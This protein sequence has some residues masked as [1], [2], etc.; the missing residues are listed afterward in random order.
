MELDICMLKPGEVM[1]ADTGLMF[2]FMIGKA[3]GIL[4]PWRKNT[5]GLRPSSL[6]LELHIVSA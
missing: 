2:L 6:I 3:R 5:D 4:C 1:A